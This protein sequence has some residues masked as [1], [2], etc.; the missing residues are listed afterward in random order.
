MILPVLPA[1]VV[2]ELTIKLPLTPAVPPLFVRMM[3]SPD[4]E[5]VPVPEAMNTEPPLDVVPDPPA[6]VS[7]PPDV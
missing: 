7:E 2:P 1:R 5:D 4:D 3:I 6:T